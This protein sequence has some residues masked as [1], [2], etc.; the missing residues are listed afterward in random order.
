M[1]LRED[2]PLLAKPGK[3]DSIVKRVKS[4]GEIRSTAR[5]IL[6]LFQF[7]SFLAFFFIS[8][9]VLFCTYFFFLHF[10]RKTFCL[11]SYNTIP[12]APHTTRN[13]TR[14]N[15]AH[16]YTLAHA[17]RATRTQLRSTH[18]FATHLRNTK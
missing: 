3:H 13:T 14:N 5:Y 2:H 12:F 9:L 8:C 16:A 6:F 18:T 10:S 17:A 7:L 11:L 4:A 1:D 15:T